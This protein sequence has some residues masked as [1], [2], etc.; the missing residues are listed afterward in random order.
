MLT[1]VET[2]KGD[3]FDI[4]IVGSGFGGSVSTYNL[5]KAGMSV[6]LL[7]RGKKY[8]P[9]EF[10]R[11]PDELKKAFWDPSANLFRAA[12]AI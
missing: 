2:L 5:T 11:S 7:E 10:A 9:G 8:A 6:C 12:R 4:V 3:T 1:G